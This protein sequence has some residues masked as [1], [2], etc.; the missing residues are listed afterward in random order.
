[1]ST[2]NALATLGLLLLQ[3][4]FLVTLA[5]V[6]L[7]RRG[8]TLR[9]AGLHKP[10]A[11]QIALGI[12]LGLAA[13]LGSYWLG[14]A[15]L[16]A[17]RVLLTPDSLRHLQALTDST[18]AEHTFARLPA[19]YVPLFALVGATVAPLGEEICFRG[20]VYNAF[21]KRYGVGIGLMGSAIIF[22]L[23]HVSPLHILPIFALGL[24]FGLAYQRTGSL[25]VAILMHVVNNSVAFLILA[26]TL[27]NS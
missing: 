8:M 2:A 13:A 16:W 25:W 22:A 12:G 15:E 3:N 1:M 24:A 20:W 5:T 10:T 14:E 17:C 4:A 19:L 26:R 6:A 7:K 9:D 11:R 27:S 18:G 21:K 23:L